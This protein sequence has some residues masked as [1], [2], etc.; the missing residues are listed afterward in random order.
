MGGRE[1]K[2]VYSLIEGTL[3]RGQGRREGDGGGG[4]G[5]GEEEEGRRLK[6]GK[7]NKDGNSFWKREG[8]G[9]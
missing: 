6:D 2:G 5:R 4:D 7:M 9:Y 3:M 1:G 8:G